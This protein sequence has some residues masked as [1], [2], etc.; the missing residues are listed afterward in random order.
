MRKCSTLIM[1]P[2]LKFLSKFTVSFVT[3]KEGLCYWSQIWHLSNAKEID[4]PVNVE[5]AN[6]LVNPQQRRLSDDSNIFSYLESQRAY[7]ENRVGV[8]RLLRV[9]KLVSR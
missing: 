8:E 2:A 7:L 4:N 9:Y 6:P 3:A 1:C 5:Q